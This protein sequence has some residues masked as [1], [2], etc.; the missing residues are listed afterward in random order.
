MGLSEEQQT[1]LAR[2]FGNPGIL[3]IPSFSMVDVLGKVVLTK[4]QIGGQPISDKTMLFYREGHLF[5][6]YR[7]GE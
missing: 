6:A 3:C 5:L 2:A 7:L 4:H 1:R